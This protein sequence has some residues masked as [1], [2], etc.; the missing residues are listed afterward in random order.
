M[1][2]WVKEAPA[3]VWLERAAAEEIDCES[4]GS[5]IGEYPGHD[6]ALDYGCGVGIATIGRRDDGEP[7]VVITWCTQ[8]IH[9]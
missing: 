9:G 8:H 5:V 1:S 7:V 2:E 3:P 6:M 4:A